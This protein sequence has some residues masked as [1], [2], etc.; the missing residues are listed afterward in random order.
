MVTELLAPAGGSF[1]AVTFRV[2][3]RGVGS[4]SA[5][6]WAVPPSSCTWKVKAA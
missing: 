4:R 3:V 2:I 5:P 1:T 6:P